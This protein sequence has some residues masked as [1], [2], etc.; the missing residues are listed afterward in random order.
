MLELT[1][2][3]WD[4][5]DPTVAASNACPIRLTAY[6]NARVPP[7][8]AGHVKSGL[9]MKGPVVKNLVTQN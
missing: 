5:R 4:L 1:L 9:R 2:A 6:G 8:W 3:E 7:N